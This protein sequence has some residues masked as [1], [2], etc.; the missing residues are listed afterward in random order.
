ML[1]EFGIDVMVLSTQCVQLQCAAAAAASLVSLSSLHVAHCLCMGLGCVQAYIKAR[2]DGMAFEVSR[3]EVQLPAAVTAQP[4]LP[5]A[6]Q[7]VQ[8]A[9]LVVDGVPQVCWRAFVQRLPN[10]HWVA[11]VRGPPADAIDAFG[12]SDTLLFSAVDDESCTVCESGRQQTGHRTACGK[13][14]HAQRSQRLC[15]CIATLW[16]W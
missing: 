2:G 1:H 3:L 12:V 15:F 9:Q 4:S 13:Q 6:G 10:R 16:L 11:V 8:C 7:P 14:R 5:W